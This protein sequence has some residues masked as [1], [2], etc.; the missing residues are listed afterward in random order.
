[1]SSSLFEEAIADAKKIRE[2]AEENAKKAVLEAVTPKI[3]EF[4]ESQI[5]EEKEDDQKEVSGCYE[6]SEGACSDSHYKNESKDEKCSS[7]GG[8]IKPKDNK[9]D[10]VQLDETAVK[11]LMKLVGGNL[12]IDKLGNGVTNTVMSEA[13][14]KLTNRER[15]K[16]LRMAKKIDG[17]VDNLKSRD[18]YR[19][20]EHKN[21]STE[22]YYEVDLQ[23][24]REALKGEGVYESGNYP[25]PMSEFLNEEDEEMEIPDMAGDDD[26][27]ADEMEG[28]E[29]EEGSDMISR[30][31][32]ER[33]IQEL[34]DDLGL[35]LGEGDM[36]AMEDEIDMEALDLGDL[37]D[38]EAEEAEESEQL[39]EVYDVDP[40]MLRQELR[41][42]KRLSESS[43]KGLA[44]ES[45]GIA[46]DYE[47][48]F[49]GKGSANSKGGDFGGGKPGKDVLAEMKHALRNQRRQNTSLQNKLTKYRGAVNTLREQL[50]ELNLFNAKLLYVNKL[51]QNKQISES[52]KRSIVQAL[53]EAKDLREAKV[54]YKSLTESFT[55][56]KP[57][58]KESL[59]ESVRYGGSSRTTRSASSQ[60][61][62]GEVNRWA[63]L[64]G[65]K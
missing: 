62:T 24:L 51:L 39:D 8:D 18:L 14:S 20:K 58:S 1:M 32:V 5:F 33:Q 13:F 35:D 31:E 41:R 15:K 38:E 17:H 9:E 50:E 16:I 34:I 63:R 30:D 57:S 28:E 56:T 46:K 26:L 19:L 65:L 12:N 4:I 23:S 55:Q 48:H 47:H 10:S 40:K 45:G 64:A 60:Q 2:V 22:K 3:R 25:N 6:T 37:E 49:G 27:L 42:I 59:T 53:D 11:E 7:C 54:L 36:E 43:E 44:H 21:M 29:A 52:Q 61:A